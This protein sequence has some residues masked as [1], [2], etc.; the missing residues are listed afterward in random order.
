MADSTVVPTTEQEQSGDKKFAG[1]K[2]EL[3]SHLIVPWK[4]VG[5][6][7]FWVKNFRLNKQ[8]TIISEEFN[9]ADSLMVPSIEKQ[10]SMDK[11]DKTDNTLKGHMKIRERGSRMSEKLSPE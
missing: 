2:K 5:G 1:Y 9:M 8:G 6:A 4:L 11:N 3:T 7:P 10:G